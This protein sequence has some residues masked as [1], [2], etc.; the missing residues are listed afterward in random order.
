M[1]ADEDRALAELARRYLAGHAPATPDDL[2]TWSGIGLRRARLAFAL[3]GCGVGDVGEGH[4]ASRSVRA[5]VRPST[6]R[7]V[8]LL[9]HFDPY[10]L[11]YA[12]RDLALARRFA[13][14]IQPGGGFIAPA[15]LADGRVIGSWRRGERD[16]LEPFE[17][18]TD[19]VLERVRRERAD[20]ERF[21]A[22][23][24]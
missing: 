2:A 7:H 13:T 1:P 22:A 12:S 9:G 10:L 11:G 15:I 6:P 23:A 20:V 8:T 21:L 19:D 5:D 18:L 3:L 24:P 4:R 14:R 17:P 16:W